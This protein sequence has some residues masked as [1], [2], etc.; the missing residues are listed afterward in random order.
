ML[1]R[2]LAAGVP[3]AWVTGDEVYGGDRRLRVWLEE[4][5]VAHLLAI[6]ATEPLWVATD[7]GPTQVAAA[8]LI[9]GLPAAAW[10]TL[11]AGDGAKG[12]RRYDWAWLPI[13][14]LPRAGAGLLAAGPPR[15]ERPRRP[16][17]LRRL[18]SGRDAVG[19]VGAGGGDALGDRNQL[20]GGEGRGRAG[21]V[22]GAALGR[23]AAARH[24]LP[25]GARGAGG[26]AGD[27]G[28]KGGADEPLTATLLPLTVPEVRRL[29]QIAWQ[30]RTEAERAFHLAWS[31][32]RRQHQAG[33]RRSHY[34]RRLG[35]HAARSPPLNSTR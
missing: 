13:R 17:L 28:K 24:P 32:W 15:A 9:A 30:A 35:G 3:F 7:R 19:R 29:L 26:G 6:K 21:R 20:R 1:E 2:A 12:P 18:R 25:V 16:G 31:H 27:R 8:A 4:Q 22:R 23:L 34:R 33:A 14:P 10:V 5:K 11:S